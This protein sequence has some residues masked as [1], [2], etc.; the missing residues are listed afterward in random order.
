[1]HQSREHKKRRSAAMKR[2]WERARVLGTDEDWRQGQSDG[3][4]R[5]MA[6]EK[7]LALPGQQINPRWKKPRV[8]DES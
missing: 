5:R 4:K 3:Q 1:M 8:W 7:A 2:A 6:V